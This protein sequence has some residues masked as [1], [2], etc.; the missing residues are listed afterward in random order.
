MDQTTS[1]RE[2]FLRNSDSAVMIQLLIAFMTFVLLKLFQRKVTYKGKL[3]MIFKLLRIDW[4]LP[5]A[6]FVRHIHQKPKRTSK[7]RRRWKHN[8]IFE[9]TLEQY[10]REETEHLED[11]MYD[12]II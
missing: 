1:L 4:D 7:G 6:I 12:P 5:F 9:F 11:S 2:T 8:E 3:L 10:E